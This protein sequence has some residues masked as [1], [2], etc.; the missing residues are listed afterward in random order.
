MLKNSIKFGSAL[1]FLAAW[2]ISTRVEA[3]PK[4][5]VSGN[6]PQK[7][8]LLKTAA[9]CNPATAS[10]DLDINNVRARL[11]NGGDM[12]W[13]HGTG[14]ARYE[15]P[16]GSKKNSLF[17]GSCWVGG[18]DAQKVLKVAA[19]MYRQDGNDVW[20]G[21]LNESKN[22]TID[23]ADCNAWDKIWKVDRT[24][25]N[26]FKELMQQGN[27]AAAQ[28]PEFDVIWEWPAR[29][30]GLG[31]KNNNMS[32][33]KRATGTTG[34]LLEMDD[35]DYAPF[36]DVGGPN[37]DP[38]I[39]NP[40][41]G[42][43]PNMENPGRGDQMAWWV[44]NDRGNIK[45]QTKTESIGLE[46]QTTAFA[47]ST[48]DFLNDATFFNY[49]VIN[50]GG[51]RLDSCYMATWTDADL[52]YAFDDYIGCDTLRGL[53]ILYNGT[54]VD[55]TGGIDHYGANPPMVGVDFFIGP[56]RYYR[57]PGTDRDTFEKLKMQA[58]TYFNNNTDTRIG[59]PD[60]G[61]QI[62]Y[63]MTGS[64]RNGQTFAYDYQGPNIPAPGLGL[65]PKIRF[66]FPGEVDRD[67]S[68]CNCKNPVADR[69]FI[70]SAGPFVLY[71]GEVNDIIIGAVWVA[72]TGGCPNTSF[73][74]IRVAD[75]QAQDLFDNNFR[76]IE[77]PEA[78]VLHV[79]E[80][81]KK[82][83]FYITNPPNS[84]NYQEKFGY[85]IDS[86]KYRVVSPK[87]RAAGSP[88]SLYKFEGY[89][90]F[91]LKS[92]TITPAQIFNERGEVDE[93]VAKE[94]FQTD[95]KNGIT[96]IVNYNK[97]ID[98]QSE[99]DQYDISIKLLSAKDSGIVHSFEI[100][101]DAFA[102]DEY[103]NLVN[104]KTYYFLAIA[105]A[106]NN[107]AQFD[108][109]SPE[110]TQDVVY[111]ES[112]HGPGGSPLGDMIVSAMP[113]PFSNMAGQYIP[114]DYGQ[115][116]VIKRL[117]GK[118]NGGNNLQI[119]QE[120]E[121]EALSASTGYKSANPTYL[122]GQGPIEVK[123]VDPVK[124]PAAN[125]TL[126]IEPNPDSTDWT[127]YNSDEKDSVIIG[128][129][130]RWRLVN[131]LDPTNVIYSERH[132][133]IANEQIL[134][135]YGLSIKVTQQIRPGENQDDLT[136]SNGLITSS[137]E[138]KDPSLT[139][140][141][142]VPDQEQRSLLNWIRAGGYADATDSNDPLNCDFSDPGAKADPNTN[143]DRNQ[144]YESLLT[145]NSATAKTWAP[146]SLGMYYI[147]T[148][149]AD[150]YCNIPVTIPSV[151]SRPTNLHNL[152]SVDIVFTSDRSKWTRCVVL[153]TTTD[154]T[155][156]QGPVANYFDIRKHPSWNGEVDA[157]GN[158]VYA[159][160]S[161]KADDSGFSYFPGYA[162]NQETGERLNIVF[163]EDSWQKSQRGADMLWNPTSDIF[164]GMGNY[165]FGGRHF[166]Y[167]L[168]SKYDSCRTVAEEMRKNVTA[169]RNYFNT[170]FMWTGMPVVNY[171][172]NLLSPKDGFIPTETRLRFRVTRPYAKY[173]PDATAKLDNN[174]YPVYSF[175][176]KDLAP[177]L[178]GDPGNPYS[179]NELLD[180]IH[181]VPNPYYASSGHY[182]ANRLDTRVRIINLPPEATVSIYSLDGSLVRRL[183]KSNKEDAY[184]DWD[185]RNAKGL[186]IASGM[187]LIHVEAKGIGE[188][189]IR[190]FG[191]LSPVDVTNY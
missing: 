32:N 89:R 121:L 58:F 94:V 60:N 188:K 75:D 66:V 133:D 41:L 177:K 182:E 29:G 54:P 174:G 163:G 103:D 120:S 190:W 24:T 2:G 115:G 71:S 147:S 68:E 86:Q 157:N 56:K 167:V 93:S 164:D 178:Y 59:N 13:D 146:Y 166:I 14:E 78:P 11:M 79:R 134:A 12:W 7:Q 152:Q 141:S 160:P 53:G 148:A 70:H 161:G 155:L 46:M 25:V 99:T 162:I 5:N 131:D 20:P 135:E 149:A 187:Y 98:I 170:Y 92:A 76:T 180:R 63:Y 175:S 129:R 55:G 138:Y 8:Q 102:T 119:D 35:R 10:I 33:H 31:P 82:L 171:G 137:V 179:K 62:Y 95:L 139:W 27:I 158:P 4:M 142:G 28:A 6:N 191:A 26:K 106:Y 112:A 1:M 173:V 105:Y 159:V 77:G 84:T 144:F 88:D 185:I 65:G 109:H 181:V 118:G 111:L 168:S 126:Y 101:K 125:W 128:T 22:F 37:N 19:Q 127:K 124:I 36:V 140:L 23:Q 38:D 97:N 73:K 172:F 189:V 43:Y 39:Y 186:P 17:S 104:Y 123:V 145:N 108:P 116:V 15:V 85:E 74:K 16:K 69:R 90:V 42:D 72:N 87:A 110:N 34:A 154:I 169:K 156:S 184:M 151:T 96:Q 176:T 136:L 91:Q 100:S 30:N 57:I 113:N 9:G 117:E 165:T 83:V 64:Q 81:D 150:I 21:P 47:F 107:F 80:L 44:F 67:W 143:A 61:V 122:A 132:I 114:A 40:E 153:E 48:K 51:I 52:G 3:L 183:T 130:A 49:R 50:R 45:Q 18:L